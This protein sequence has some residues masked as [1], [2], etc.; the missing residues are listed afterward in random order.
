MAVAAAIKVGCCSAAGVSACIRGRFCDAKVVLA[1][2]AL[3]VVS[4]WPCGSCN[5]A[6]GGRMEVDAP[7]KD[8]CCSAAGVTACVGGR[9]CG[10]V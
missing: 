2:E 7:V 6:S 1:V 10:G 5:A 4:V 3:H 9:S 8:G